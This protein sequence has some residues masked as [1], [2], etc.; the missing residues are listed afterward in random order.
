MNLGGEGTNQDL[1]PGAEV[2]PIPLW[3]KRDHTL[4]ICGLAHT[5]FISDWGRARK[6]Q[7][8][9]SQEDAV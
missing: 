3:V 1:S 9:V 4:L 6:E 2:H 5:S 7:I 8:A